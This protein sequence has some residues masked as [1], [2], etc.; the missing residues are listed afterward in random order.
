[1]AGHLAEAANAFK[2][3]AVAARGSLDSL[4]QKGNIAPSQQDANAK[5][6][7]SMSGSVIAFKK[8]QAS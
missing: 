8:E 1:M 5:A 4:E 7:Q 6:E 3:L 2:G